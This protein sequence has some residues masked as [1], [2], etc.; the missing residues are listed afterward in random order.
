MRTLYI[1]FFT[2]TFLSC[3]NSSSSKLVQMVKS[4]M[5]EK[6]E[7]EGIDDVEIQNLTLQMVDDNTYTGTLETIENGEYYSYPVTVEVKGDSFE[8]EIIGDENTNIEKA[9]SNTTC[10]ICGN[11]FSG[12]GYEEQID[13]SWA[14]LDDNLQGTICSPRCGRKNNEKLNDIVKEYEES[15]STNQGDYSMGNDGMVHENNAC[16]LCK[17]TGIET[18]RNIVT[19]EEDG[20]ICPMCDGKGARSY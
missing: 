2:L 9:D 6:W 1:L 20:R 5:I 10:S 18:G 19:G 14:E 13:G 16:S 7:Q 3:N 11:S 17:G 15:N 4:S 8:W 12:N